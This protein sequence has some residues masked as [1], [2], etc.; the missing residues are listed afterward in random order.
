MKMKQKLI[1]KGLAVAVIILFLGLA[2]QPSVAVQSETEI[3]IESEQDIVSEPSGLFWGI[4]R[5]CHIRGNHDGTMWP[6][7]D[8]SGFVFFVSGSFWSCELYGDKG[9]IPVNKVR[10]FGFTGWITQP[11]VS[12]SYGEIDGHLLFCIYR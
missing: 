10:G 12:H 4:Y 7:L 11:F 1:C 5:N 3:E 9:T 2:I 6:L 8:R